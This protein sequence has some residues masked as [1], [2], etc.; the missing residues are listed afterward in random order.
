MVS[1][2]AEDYL[3]SIFKLEKESTPVGTRKI[4]EFLKISSA[5]VTKMLQKLEGQKLVNYASYQGVRLTKKG[6]GIALATLRRHRLLELFLK[7]ELGYSWDEVHEEAER[8]EHHVSER[9]VE[10]IAEILGYPEFDPHGDPIP[11]E[12]GELPSIDS[13]ALALVKAPQRVKICRVPD[14]DSELL[15]YLAEIR[16][17]PGQVVQ[18]QDQAPFQGPLTLKIGRKTQILGWELARKIFV[19]IERE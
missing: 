14:G 5:S 16:V 4:A 10:R 13:E 2:A 6:A 7:E 18:V 11:N 19:S 9:F 3:K 12:H 15:Q 1:Q 8:L 17:V